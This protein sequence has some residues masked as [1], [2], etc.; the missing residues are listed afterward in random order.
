MPHPIM[1]DEADPLLAR[2]R[3]LALAYPKAAE[4]VSHG[5][6]VFFT[7]TIFLWFGGSVKTPDGYVQHDR[8]V[9]VRPTPEEQ[10]AIDEDPRF[11][12]PA[13]LAGYGWRGLDLTDDVDWDEV[14]ELIEDSYRTTADVK[15][16]SEL[17]AR[18]SA[19]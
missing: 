3:E 5:R 18:R 7:K 11:F 9:L 10:Q 14:A 2:V 13:Y 16:V 1:F 17:D 19:R 6:P 8:A 4:K 15:L 12:R